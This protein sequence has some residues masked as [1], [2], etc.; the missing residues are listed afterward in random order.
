VGVTAFA[1]ALIDELLWLL[2]GGAVRYEAP[3]EISLDKPVA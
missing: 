1:I 2:N 3:D